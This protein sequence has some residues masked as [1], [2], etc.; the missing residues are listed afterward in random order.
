MLTKVGLDMG[1]RRQLV[2]GL[3]LLVGGLVAV[4]IGT[5][6][7]SP[8]P[9]VALGYLLI[10]PIL[11]SICGC[12]FIVVGLARSAEGAT[13]VTTVFRIVGVSAMCGLGLALGFGAAGMLSQLPDSLAGLNGPYIPGSAPGIGAFV[14][15]GIGLSLG[16]VIGALAALVWWVN[17]GRHPLPP[18]SAESPK[19][20]SRT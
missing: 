15:G 14:L 11:V 8:N 12:I 6:Y 3:V 9:A 5:T 19:V 13:R 2:V 1:N 18:Q 17:R 7:P 4:A 20:G 16:L 10:V